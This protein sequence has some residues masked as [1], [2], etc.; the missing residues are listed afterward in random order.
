VL[1]PSATASAGVR[2]VVTVATGPKTSVWKISAA[3]STPSRKQGAKKWPAAGSGAAARCRIAPAF[4][5]SPTSLA[6]RRSCSSEI[7]RLVERIADA[8]RLQ[9]LAQALHQAGGDALLNED[10]RTGAADLALIEPDRVD[11]AF[12][13]RFQVGV[14]EDDER[15]LAAEFQRQL[16]A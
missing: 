5:A 9:A 8:Q 1:L 14:V 16:L 11:D 6:T 2:K 10:A 3:G 4:S 12:D 7:H 13:R 15:R